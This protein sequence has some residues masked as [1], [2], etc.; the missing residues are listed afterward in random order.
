MLSTIESAGSIVADS[1]RAILETMSMEPWSHVVSVNPWEDGI[2]QRRMQFIYEI[3]SKAVAVTKFT[4]TYGDT[5]IDLTC[6]AGFD[7]YPRLIPVFDG[8]AV[9]SPFEEVVG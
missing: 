8:I 3:D 1:A 4:A 7:V 5:R 9:T 2:F 6:S